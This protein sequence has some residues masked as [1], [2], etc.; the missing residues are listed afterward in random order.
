MLYTEEKSSFSISILGKSSLTMP[1]SIK[2]SRYIYKAWLK[3]LFYVR[4]YFLLLSRRCW[5]ISTEVVHQS[6]HKT[7]SIW[8]TINTNWP[9]Q[10]P[11]SLPGQ[12]GLREKEKA[13]YRP[14]QAGKKWPVASSGQHDNHL[15]QW[16]I[17]V[18]SN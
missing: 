15:R 8:K 5:V 6:Y 13:G 11:D 12:A 2:L 4:I 17:I 18:I 7:Q 1:K 16:N 9:V 10:V 3:S 14:D